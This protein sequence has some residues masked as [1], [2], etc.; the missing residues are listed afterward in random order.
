MGR[1]GQHGYALADGAGGCRLDRHHRELL[2]VLRQCRGK[3]ILSGYPS[4]LYDEAL[5][6]WSRHTF[7]MPNNA[8]GGKKKRRQTEM[9]WCSFY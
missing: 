1:G 8:A 7:P 5:A 2:A 4:R 9:V 3:V 6:G